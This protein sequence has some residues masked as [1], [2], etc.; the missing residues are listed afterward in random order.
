MI[1]VELKYRLDDPEE[2]LARLIAHGATPSGE[3]VDRDQY[4]A[5]P[6]RDFAATNE[7]LRLRWDGQAATMT[8]KGP[9]LDSVSKTRE[10]FEFELKDSPSLEVAGQLLERL[11]FRAVRVVEKRR[12]KFSVPWRGAAVT[13]CLDDVTGAGLFLE[14]EVLAPDGAWEAARDSLQALGRSLGLTDSERRSYLE[15]VLEAEIHG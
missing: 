12:T 4:F 15:L 3:S 8:Y 5:H 9:L 13:A 11:G 14:L 2:A 6:V 7:A 1:E 10:E